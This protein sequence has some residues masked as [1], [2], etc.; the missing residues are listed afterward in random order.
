MHT[1]C[2]KTY[3]R[4]NQYKCPTCR[5][6][7]VD[8]TENWVMF[9]AAIAAQPMPDEYVKDVEVL[10]YDCGKDST[11]AFHFMGMECAHCGSYNTSQK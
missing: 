11:A 2:Y 5:K 10:C 1:K 3:L 6:S 4:S 7:I 8:M 9:K